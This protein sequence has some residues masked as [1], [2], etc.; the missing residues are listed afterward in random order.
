MSEEHGGDIWGAARALGVGPGEIT[1]FSASITPFGPGDAAL[2]AARR[3][4]RLAGAYPDRSMRELRGALARLYGVEEGEVLPGNG[5]TEFIYLVPAVFAPASA[6]VVDPC[7]SEYR[8]ALEAY[9]CRVE[10]LAAREEDRFLPDGDELF[11]A[12]DGGGYDLVWL[13]NPANPTGAAMEREFVV[14]T[15]RRCLRRGAVLVVDEAFADFDESLSVKGDAVGMENLVVLRSMTK[16]F[17]LAGLRVGAVVACRAV[18]ERFERLAPPWSVNVAAAAAAV[19]AIDDAAHAGRI[20]RWLRDEAPR[21][22]RRIEATGVCEVFPSAANYFLLKLRPP[23]ITGRHVR[24]LLFERMMLVR[25]M[26]GFRGLDDRFLRV[27]VRLPAE[28]DML[29]RGLAA[30]AASGQRSP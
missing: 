15:A 20:R 22:R 29:A 5:S 25:D 12:V 2:E 4:L 14:E 27:A 19:A 26:R 9:G 6:L 7:F 3:A 8:A 10:G 23:G 16:F 21:M 30:A 1:D 17:A 18:I 24:K 28:N 13:A 11:A